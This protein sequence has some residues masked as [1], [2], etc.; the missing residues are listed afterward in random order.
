MKDYN[1]IFKY[2]Q[3]GVYPEVE[4]LYAFGDIHGDLNA[5]TLCLKNAKL[6][7]NKLNWCGGTAHAV[8]VGDILDR[9]IRVSE[10]SDEDSEIKIISL[11]CSLQLQAYKAGGG[12]HPVIGTHEVMNIMGMFEF[13]SP[14]GMKH[15]KDANG[16]FEYFRIGNYFCKY[17]ACGWN[18]VIKIGKF[19]FCHGGLSLNIVQ[20]Y[21]IETINLIMR[22]TLYGNVGHIH[23]KYFAELF[24]DPSSILWNRTYSSDVHHLQEIG[25]TKDLDKILNILGAKFIVV[26]HTPQDNGIKARF[27]GKIICIDT[28]MS[29]AFGKKANKTDR[30]HFIEIIQNKNENKIVLF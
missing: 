3:K 8:Q 30:I 26:G 15:F 17:L 13:V 9:K 5:F 7:D 24:L 29:E 16:R 4:K 19:V 10:Y 12:F 23:Q 27:G 2:Y 11:I 28:A 6:I 18:P 20:K 22:D 25:M 1:E 14:M 21:N